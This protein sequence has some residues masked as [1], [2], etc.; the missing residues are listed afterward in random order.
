M[1]LTSRSWV[2]S[3]EVVR[4]CRWAL[5]C[6]LSLLVLAASTLTHASGFDAAQVGSAQSGP[7]S[8]D[9]AAAWWNPGRLGYLDEAE[10]F[11]GAGLTIG[12]IGYQR[13]LLGQYQYADNL[14]FAE[15]ISPSDIDASRTGKQRRVDD[16]PFGPALDLFFASPKMLDGLVVGAGLAIPY[17]ASLSL[18]RSGPQRFAGQ[19]LFLAA[20]HA[21]LAIASRLNDILSIGAGVSYVL[22]NMALSKTQDFGAL[23][24]FGDILARPPI[25]QA[26]GFGT[27]APSTLRELDTLAR[28]LT[29]DDAFAHG[30]TF[31]VGLALQPSEKLALG[32]V[33]HHGADLRFRGKFRLDMSDDFFTQDLA[34]E[35]LDYDAVVRGDAVV[36]LRLPHR[37]TLGAGYQ[38]AR[39]FGLDGFVSYVSSQRLDRVGIRLESPG[40]AREALGVGDTVEQDV[41]RN[42]KGALLAEVNARIDA[43]DE[44]RLSVTAGYHSPASPDATID[45]ISVDGHRIIVGGGIAYRFTGRFALLADVEGQYLVPR[46]VTSSDYDLGNGTY[47]LFIAALTL[48][49]QF[50]FGSTT[51]RFHELRG[52]GSEAAAPAPDAALLAATLPLETHGVR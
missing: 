34:A 29:I 28:P 18:P 51:A 42:W 45:I 25:D 15:P 2:R 39:S 30:V 32:L 31:N 20:P 22:G 17:V 16:M 41:I 38:I 1:T 37:L 11:A 46:H 5:S 36:H 40:L 23:D 44:L 33:Y 7:V 21:T 26:N 13:E 35:G 8:N 14:D 12:S 3:G 10:L 6:L 50:R 49:G 48:H 52:E 27:S 19:S 9:A 43:S 4:A 47:D 24:T